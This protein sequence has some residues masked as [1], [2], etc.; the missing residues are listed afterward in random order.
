MAESSERADVQQQMACIRQTLDEDVGKVVDH[1]RDLVNWRNIVKRRPWLAVG[2]AAAA[3][4]FLAPRRPNHRA[5][6]AISQLSEQVEALR[7]DAESPAVPS[8][9]MVAPVMSLLASAAMRS[10]THI[11][12]QQVSK[13][14]TA[15]HPDSDVPSSSNSTGE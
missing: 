12:G 10:V 5:A 3:G 13:L 6:S 15:R 2:V 1:A 7:D 11:V 9:S 4:Y 14:I 8:S